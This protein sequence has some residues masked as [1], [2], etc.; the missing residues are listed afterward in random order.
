MAALLSEVGFDPPWD[1]TT[2]GRAGTGSGRAVPGPARAPPQRGACAF[3]AI[4]APMIVCTRRGSPHA[5]PTP[6]DCACTSSAAVQRAGR[7]GHPRAKRAD[8]VLVRGSSATPWSG[9]DRPTPRPRMVPGASSTGTDHQHRPARHGGTVAHLHS[10]ASA[11]N[12]LVAE[13]TPKP[14]G[15]SGRRDLPARHPGR[16]VPVFFVQAALHLP[17]GGQ[18]RG[19]GDGRARDGR[20]ELV[21]MKPLGVLETLTG[22]PRG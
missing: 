21:K 15:P 16:F 22:F 1:R 9:H 19:G 5:A 4:S 20:P 18:Q 7:R 3:E 11:W 8:R 17:L 13:A 12:R 10:L 14:P 2:G 6:S